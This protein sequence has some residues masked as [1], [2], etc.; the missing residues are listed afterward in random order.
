MIYSQQNTFADGQRVAGTSA[1]NVFGRNAIDLGTT[2]RPIGSAAV[3]GR[4]VGQGIRIPIRVQLTEAFVSGGAGFV[5]ADTMNVA[6]LA[7]DTEPTYGTNGDVSAVSNHTTIVRTGD[8]P[9]STLD[10]TGD[11]G[12]TLSL[13]YLTRG[14]DKRF[15][16]CRF[17]FTATAA[18]KLNDTDA[19]GAFFAGVVAANEE[20]YT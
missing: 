6:I 10:D 16:V 14:T 1:T 12:T 8:I 20:W 4:D 9:L 18:A 19:R 3:L 13:Q 17:N 5:A 15:V 11:I 2:G 7:T